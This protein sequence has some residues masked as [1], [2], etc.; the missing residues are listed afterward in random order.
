MCDLT[1]NKPLNTI[2]GAQINEMSTTE[3]QKAIE[4]G[5]PNYLTLQAMATELASR[6]EHLEQTQAA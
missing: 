4:Q 1:I 6:C 5:S 2:S 3:L